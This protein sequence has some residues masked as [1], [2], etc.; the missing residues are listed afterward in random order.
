[1]GFVTTLIVPIFQMEKLRVG[2]VR[3]VVEVT[4]ESVT[5]MCLASEVAH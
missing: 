4:E 2:E 5:E 3:D 1:M